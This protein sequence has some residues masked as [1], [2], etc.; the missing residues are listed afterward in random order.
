ML[1]FTRKSSPH[2]GLEMMTD[3]IPLHLH[4]RQIASM[5]HIRTHRFMQF[6]HEEMKTSI[7]LRQGHCQVI[8]KYLIDAGIQVT[9]FDVDR[10]PM[11]QNWDNKFKIDKSFLD[12]LNKDAGKPKVDLD[13]ANF[14]EPALTEQS[15]DKQNEK[16]SLEIYSDG[17]RNDDI[18]KAGTGLVVFFN[19]QRIFSKAFQ[20]GDRTVY[21][22]ECYGLKQAALWLLNIENRQRIKNSKVNIYTDNQAVVMSLDNPFIK[23]FQVRETLYLL[24]EAVKWTG[25]DITINWVR[26]L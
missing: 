6:T 13:W 14:M 2:R 9:E 8:R 7:K 4:I 16:D 21:Q 11:E 19:T 12:P 1:G 15:I 25:A 26:G 18:E 20:I 3:T 24:N 23:S 17:S 5:E 10:I 22:S